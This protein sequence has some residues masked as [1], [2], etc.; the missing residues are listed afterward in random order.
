[1]ALW[2]FKSKPKV[3]PFADPFSGQ[4]VGPFG[5]ATSFPLQFSIPDNVYISPSAICLIVTTT[6]GIRA[7]TGGYLHI[8]RGGLVFT[9]TNWG[10]L[11]SSHTYSI[12]FAAGLNVEAATATISGRIHALP[13]PLYLYPHDLI[14]IDNAS[15][16]AG[17]SIDSVTLH[18]KYWETY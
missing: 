10:S 6:A 1:M 11:Q 12:T 9:A 4:L 8:L 3:T 16:I 2:P 7:T 13:Y 18:G 17:D 14:E 15:F 5:P